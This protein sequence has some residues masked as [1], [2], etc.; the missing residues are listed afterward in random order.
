M[1]LLLVTR[2]FPPRSGGVET[3]CRQLAEGFAGR[4][5]EVTVVTFGGR[6]ARPSRQA[7]GS[8]GGYEVLRLPSRGGT[9]EWSGAFVPLLRRLDADV[10]HVHNLHSSVAAAVWRS[11]RRPYVLTAHY[12]GSGHSVAARLAHR[13]Y[14]SLARRIVAGAAAVTA[15][16]DSEAALITRDF[17]IRP[18]VIPNGIPLPS[19]S[20]AA[21]TSTILVVSR[22][23]V[24]KRVDAVVRALPLLPTF[25]LHIVGD[26]PARAGL[27]KLAADL[28]VRERVTLSAPALSEEDLHHVYR[29]AA[30]F[31]NLSAAEAFSY[32]VLE[33]L[34]AGTPVVTSGA[35]ALAEWSRRFPVAVRAADPAEPATVAAAIRE[36]AGRRVHV[37]LSRYDLPAVLDAYQRLYERLWVRV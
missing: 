7:I 12:H 33:A 26:G 24:Y 21:M 36:L 18:E 20:S 17:G 4:G 22:L 35:A 10:C 23:E 32:T 27:E 9:F 5:D 29:E 31:V 6:L 28:G 15:V 2:G 25:T 11:G 3:L 34:S 16:S 30:V 1:R 13:P 8:A 19:M 37:D 14:R